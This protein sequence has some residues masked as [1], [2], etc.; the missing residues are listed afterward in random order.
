MFLSTTA[1][2]WGCDK[3]GEVV[4]PETLGVSQVQTIKAGNAKED[5]DDKYKTDKTG[6]YVSKDVQVTGYEDG[7]ER[8]TRPKF[9]AAGDVGT[10]DDAPCDPCGPGGGSGIAST[11][12]SSEG[13]GS[14]GGS[15]NPNDY[16]FA[17]RLIV[18]S[19]YT[20]QPS[21][22]HIKINS[23]LNRG[24]GGN[25]I[26]LTYSRNPF[27]SYEKYSTTSSVTYSTPITDLMGVSYSQACWN[28][29][30]FCD[31]NPWPNWKYMYKFDGNSSQLVDLNDGAG[32]KY[33]FGH[34]YRET[35]G[36]RT[37]IKEVGILSGNS[38]SIQ[39]PTGWLKD[40]QD[41]NENAGGDFIY[42]CYNKGGVTSGYTSLVY[43]AKTSVQL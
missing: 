23:D 1:F 38:S 37:P 31:A 40:P 12:V 41:L 6:Q 27:Y 2:L 43:R 17:L 8:P 21:T 28:F 35:D 19:S 20:I 13:G 11:F 3:A 18:G 36:G 34:V 15:D 10:K 33:I 24:A 7:S 32:G 29:Q 4:Q 39:P 22:G 42:F 9:D 26:Y 16:I 5:K 30:N 25:I 14:Y